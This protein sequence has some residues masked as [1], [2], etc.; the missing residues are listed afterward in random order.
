MS[1]KIQ[2]GITSDGT[3]YVIQESKSSGVTVAL[4][5]LL[6]FSSIIS[7]LYGVASYSRPEM[8]EIAF[9]NKTALI[10]LLVGVVVMLWVAVN[11]ISD[12]G[13][14]TFEKIEGSTRV[15]AF[16]GVASGFYRGILGLFG[17]EVSAVSEPDKGKKL[18]EQVQGKDDYFTYDAISDDQPFPAYMSRVLKSLSAYAKSSEVT[19]TRLLD[20]GVAFMA[21]GLVF[22]ILAIIIWQIFANLTSPDA[23]VMY[24]G[25]AACSMTFLV[26]EFLAAW[27]FKQYRYYVEVSLACL[28]VRSVYD[29]YLLGY[30]VARE[31][32][33]DTSEKIRG[34]LADM[35]KEDVKWPSYK[36]GSAN[37]FNYMVESMGAANATMERVRG[38]FKK[39]KNKK[40]ESKAE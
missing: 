36:S 29:R 1:K 38:M 5:T 19:A 28:R 8:I 10:S 4:A 40:S 34:Q 17:V 12:L 33:E 22:Y 2:S 27:F 39:K 15:S 18:D 35:L 11:R 24:V 6:G 37:D 9:S 30:Y 26:I 13:S 23:H 16:E 20:K 14:A 25:M 21:G 3:R 31:F 32:S 7:I